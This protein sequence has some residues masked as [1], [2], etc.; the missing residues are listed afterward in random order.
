MKEGKNDSNSVKWT[1]ATLGELFETVTGRTPPKKDKRNYGDH[2]LF[3]KPPDID[4]D[5]IGTSLSS[6]SAYGRKASRIAP[7]ASVLVTCIGNLG[8]IGLLEKEAAFNQQI[9]AIYP[10]NE[11]LPKFAF[12]QARSPSFKRQLEELSSATTVAIVNKGKFN[13]ISFSYPPLPEQRA[14]VAKLEA[15][16]GELD[17]SVAEL[18]V[19]REKLGVYRQSVLDSLVIGNSSKSI[20]DLVISL[21]QGWS[22]KCKRIARN[23][24]EQWAVIKTS[25]LQPMAFIE[26]ENKVLPDLLEPREQHE[27]KEGDI[28]VTRAGPRNRVGICCHVRSVGPRLMICD[29]VYRLKLDTEKVLASYF[30]Y[31]LNT[32]QVANAID[33]IKTGGNDSGLNLTQA[34]FLKLKIPLPTLDQQHQIVQEIESRFSVA[35]RLER[36]IEVSL[37]RAGGLRQ[38]VLKRAF[39]GELV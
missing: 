35:D 16:F 23:S 29:K 22:P 28:L 10:S 30:E 26:S 12:Y 5:F 11:V 38:G 6:I 15:V 31:A 4:N 24:P 18:A 9:N 13:T 7:A 32:P 25:A 3:I 39:G 36:E 2:T 20:N 33:R 27:I 19:A 14:I 37:E 21:S 8:R 34:R 1:T 17:R